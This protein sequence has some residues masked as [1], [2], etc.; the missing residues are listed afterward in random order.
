MIHQDN[1][2]KKWDFKPQKWCKRMG[3][4][5]GDVQEEKGRVH[6][7]SQR[8]VIPK[9]SH[10]SFSSLGTLGT[11]QICPDCPDCSHWSGIEVPTKNVKGSPCVIDLDD[12]HVLR[13]WLWS[14]GLCAYF[15]ISWCVLNSPTRYNL[16]II[17]L[18]AC[19][20]ILAF[21]ETWQ[22][23]LAPALH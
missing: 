8:G 1:I 22:L 19:L 2:L 7:G 14:G 3:F 21:L 20:W 18:D 15:D 9:L 11:I 17:D 13:W 4:S 10:L 5:T 12:C 16:D 23:F 6:D